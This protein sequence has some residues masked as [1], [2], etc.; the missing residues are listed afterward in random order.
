MYKKLSILLLTIFISITLTN[1]WYY[2]KDFN[3][4]TVGEKAEAEDGFTGTAGKSYYSDQIVYEGLSAQLNAVKGKS[5]FG[6]WGGLLDFP[7]LGHG[8]EVWIRL[9]T[10]FP[11]SF[12]YTAS[13]K[14]KFLRLRT[15]HDDGSNAGYNDIL[16][17]RP[18]T[19]KDYHFFG[20]KEGNYNSYT[21]GNRSHKIV[22]D[23]WE[24]YEWYVKLDN[25]SQDEGGE[26]VVRF[27]KN[28]ELVDEAS[29]M[30][31]LEFETDSADF[32]YLFSY[33]NSNPNKDSYISTK[34]VEGNFI[35]GEHFL[36][37]S[38]E[39]TTSFIVSEIRSD[40]EI[41]LETR[42]WREP[43]NIS[44]GDIVEGVDSGA[45]FEVEKIINEY[46]IKNQS[47]YVD[48]IVYTNERP[49]NQD[50]Y[51][52]Y[53][54]GASS[55][56]T[57]NNNDSQ[58]PATTNTSNST[59]NSFSCDNLY[60][61]DP[62]IVFCDGFETADLRSTNGG[63]FDWEGTMRTSI[64]TQDEE[65]GAVAVYNGDDIYTVVGHSRNWNALS[66]NYSMRFRFP[67]D[68]FMAEQR[69]NLGGNS[70]EDIWISYA[71]RVPE[72][73]KHGSLN[74]KFL[75][76]WP[77]QYDRSGTVTWQ[78]R[79]DGDTGGAQF[80]YQDGGV[81][82]GET[83]WTP[84]ITYPNDQ[85]RWMQVIARVKSATGPDAND[86]VIEFY[87][88]WEDEE[89][90]QKI[91]EKLNADTWDDSA[92]VQGISQGYLM[93]WAND[94]YDENTEWLL[95]N[96]V[97]STDSLLYLFNSTT[98]DEENDEDNSTV[99]N[100][101]VP[102]NPSLSLD[103]SCGDIYSNDPNIFFCD[104]LETADLR[105][106]NN[107]SFD[108]G[109]MMRTSVVTM[110]DEGP[111]AVYNKGDIYNR[112]SEFKNWS[113]LSGNH[114][115]RFRYP[116]GGVMA[117]QRFDFA[118]NSYD[119]LWIKYSVRVPVNFKHGSES[120]TNHK[121]LALW[122][123]GY[124]NKGE[125]STVIWEFW[126]TGEGSSRLAFHSS[127]V[128]YNSTGGHI[129]HF[130]FIDYPEDQGRWMDVV[131]HVK[132]STEPNSEDG[133]IE[134]YRKWTDEE[135]YAREHYKDNANIG[136]PEGKR[137][138]QSGYFMGWANGAYENETEWLIDNVVFSNSSLLYLFN[139]TYLN[140]DSSP[141]TN[142]TTPTNST[143]EDTSPDDDS[144]QDENSNDNSG[145]GSSS[146]SSGSSGSSSSGGGGGGSSSSSSNSDSA[147]QD[148]GDT[149]SSGSAVS[150]YVAP[151]CQSDF[152]YSAWSSC[153]DGT[154][155]RIVQ[156]QNSCVDATQETRICQDGA[157]ENEIK[158]LNAKEIQFAKMN[159]RR[160][161][162]SFSESYN[163]MV[164]TTEKLEDESFVVVDST[165]NQQYLGTLVDEEPGK[166][167]YTLERVDQNNLNK[168]KERGLAQ[169][170][171]TESVTSAYQNFK[172]SQN[173]VSVLVILSLFGITT[174]IYLISRYMKRLHKKSSFE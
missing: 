163:E 71:V 149:G 6:T 100:P 105:S 72:N 102:S 7:N 147:D 91:H 31:T 152:T 35:E 5:G 128:G 1:A 122:M 134:L 42:N 82:S 98:S 161:E 21:F 117:E 112:P 84:F 65:D 58:E 2:E 155:F 29:S 90:F 141:E 126:K 57:S 160:Y 69:F 129:Q 43:L 145:G 68:E 96:F 167:Y 106:T 123:D 165:T 74:N 79:P 83:G 113:A 140:G 87:V 158:E 8:D 38:K 124:S 115:I 80:V 109:H 94:A 93:G 41:I 125:G 76:V 146:G 10:Y 162:T 154:Q 62:N 136:I 132:A 55:N 39:T 64:V 150:S 85:G 13:P 24:T 4:G 121:F 26:G 56:H 172:N 49:Q 103:F 86:G 18:D 73:F 63:N 30:E 28:G 143:D 170:S 32:F 107:G 88:K 133:V 34:G 144:S 48:D 67:A 27:W 138:F 47:M 60:S 120:P 15:T 14:L 52:N 37:N 20:S 36:V 44:V 77:N 130:D 131:V 99:D 40:N 157:D 151:S 81:T 118:G 111:V 159:N 16:I 46:P 89:N 33:W 50:A 148:S 78:T 127:G 153:V 75:S 3:Q 174:I 17:E 139:Q 9:R 142:T 11:S 137:G 54:I 12:D 108:W 70:Y 116:A 61:Q 22:S 95:D 110:D 169:R 92:D 51:G 53:F 25:K 171:L 97:V 135:N 156:D 59:L 45:R 104:G 168:L 164:Y 119:D 101:S 66:G 23:T 19:S 173:F 114:S 166:Y